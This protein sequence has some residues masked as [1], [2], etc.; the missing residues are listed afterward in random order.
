[1][2]LI[3]PYQTRVIF[4]GMKTDNSD[5]DCKLREAELLNIL[6]KKSTSIHDFKRLI[7]ARSTFTPKDVPHMRADQ[8]AA[9]LMLSPQTVRNIR[10][11]YRKKGLKAIIG[12]AGRG[13]RRFNNSNLSIAR[14]QT[15]L[16]RSCTLDEL[17][18]R[19]L[20]SVE[21]LR[22]NYR[23]ATGRPPINPT[24][25]RLMKRYGCRRLAVGLYTP[26]AISKVLPSE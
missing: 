3:A 4:F 1:M 17:Y 2:Y 24:I 8:I 13:G 18:E 7:C 20:I 19:P 22:A 12:I 21:R 14:E 23:K 5:K 25:Y 15:L 6:K 26:P 16:Y 9:L 10:S 11:T